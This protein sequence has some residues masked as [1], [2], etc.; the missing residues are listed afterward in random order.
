MKKK[1]H[2]VDSVYFQITYFKFV[3]ILSVKT[4]KICILFT[5]KESFWDYYN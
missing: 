1:T 5:L 2:F 3:N 4:I